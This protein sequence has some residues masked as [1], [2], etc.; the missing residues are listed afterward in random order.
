MPS[1][2]INQAYCMSSHTL[3]WIIF[4]PITILYYFFI[5]P[6]NLTGASVPPTIN[7]GAKSK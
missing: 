4:N 2:K 5:R 3:L 1:Y 7:K 6:I